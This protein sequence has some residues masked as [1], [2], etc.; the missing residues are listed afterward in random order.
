LA[1]K[2][3]LIVFDFVEVEQESWELQHET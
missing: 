1:Q 3:S 2:N